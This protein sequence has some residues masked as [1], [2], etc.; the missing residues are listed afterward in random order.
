M[1]RVVYL[2]LMYA[3]AYA[4]WLIYCVD[5]LFVV[6]IADSNFNLRG[7]VYCFFLLGG[8][9]ALGY[10]LLFR[11]FPWAGRTLRKS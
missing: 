6:P 4:F 11:V 3:I 7:S 1:G 2:K 9:P 5:K 10:L 8:V